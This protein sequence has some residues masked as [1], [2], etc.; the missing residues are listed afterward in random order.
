MLSRLFSSIGIVKA[1]LQIYEKVDYIR[2]L[3]SAR[4]TKVTYVS[5]RLVL[6]I[7]DSP[8]SYISV[9]MVIDVGDMCDTSSTPS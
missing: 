9:S 1:R 2:V 6:N 5:L 8:H 4:T 3:G 7:T